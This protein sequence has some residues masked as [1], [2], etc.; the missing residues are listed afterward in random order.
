MRVVAEQRGDRLEGHAAVDGL[1][2]QGVAQLVG[3]DVPEPG[4]GGGFV[5]VAG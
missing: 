3:V 1:G 4:G 5:Q 2:G